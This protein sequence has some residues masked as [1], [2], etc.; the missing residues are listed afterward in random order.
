MKFLSRKMKLN[1]AFWMFQGF[2]IHLFEQKNTQVILTGGFS[3]LK[4]IGLSKNLYD[5]YSSRLASKL[6]PH[7]VY[8]FQ[9]I[10]ISQTMSNLNH[11]SAL[12]NLH[13]IRLCLISRLLWWWVLFWGYWLTD[14]ILKQ[15][16]GTKVAMKDPYH[17]FLL[18]QK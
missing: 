14:A 10:N 7:Y 5:C 2:K 17:Y 6:S 13:Y 11:A 8:Q 9:T 4:K 12:H 16:Q 15:S 3:L 18:S 1:I